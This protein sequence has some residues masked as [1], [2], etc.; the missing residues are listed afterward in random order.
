MVRLLVSHI[1]AK[2]YPISS[3]LRRHDHAVQGPQHSHYIA[4]SMFRPATVGRKY[5][6]HGAMATATMK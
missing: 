4:I 3:C 2:L 1:R 6:V 5:L